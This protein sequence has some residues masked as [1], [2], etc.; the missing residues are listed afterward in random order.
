MDNRRRAAAL[1]GSAAAVAGTTPLWVQHAPGGDFAA[2]LILG[3]A[4]SLL[5]GA[6][7]LLRR[8]KTCPRG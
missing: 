8:G 3:L 2:G 7:F 5:A 1:C 6:G 4:V